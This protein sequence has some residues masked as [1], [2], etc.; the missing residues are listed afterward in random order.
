[1]TGKHWFRKDVLMPIF[2]ILVF[3]AGLYWLWEELIDVPKLAQSDFVRLIFRIILMIYALLVLI[4]IRH[5]LSTY[6]LE[7]YDPGDP[8]SLKRLL[9]R[10]RFRLKARQIPDQNLVT[11]LEQALLDAHFRLESESHLLGRVYRRRQPEGFLSRRSFDRVIILQHEPLNVMLVDQ[12]LQDCIRL[13]RSQS[14]RPSRRNML[15]LVTRMAD[16]VDAASAAA[17][18]VNFLG[19]FKGGTLCPLLLA[20]RQNRLF[21]PADRTLLPRSHRLFQNCL[22][23]RLKKVIRRAQR[24]AAQEQ[25]PEP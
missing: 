22:I 17:G 14:E 1:M 23:F 8:A 12:L 16:E 19:K 9:R 13:I 15:I 5:V 6:D 24:D 25:N 4:S 2:Y 3:G 20:T 18:V 11:A 21:Y 10:R 7:R